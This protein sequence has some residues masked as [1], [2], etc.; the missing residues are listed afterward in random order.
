MGQVMAFEQNKEPD[1]D[2]ATRTGELAMLV[3]SLG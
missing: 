3:Y 2:M 1:P